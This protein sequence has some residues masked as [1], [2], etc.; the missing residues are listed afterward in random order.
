MMDERLFRIAPLIPP[1]CPL[2]IY[3]GGALIVNLMAELFAN[4]KTVL[5]PVMAAGCLT[6]APIGSPQTAGDP[7]LGTVWDLK[8]LYADAAA[9]E[10]DRASVERSLPDLAHLQ[11]SLGKDAASLQAGL[12]RISRT[13]QRLTRLEEYARLKADEDTSIAENQARWQSFTSLQAKFEEAIAFL[14]PE[15]LAMGRE[16]I[17]SFEREDPKLEC[18]RRELELILRRAPHTLSPE[19]ESLVA[20]TGDMRAGPSAIHDLLTYSDIPWPSIEVQGKPTRVDMEG[21]KRL[22]ENPDRD[23]RRKAFGAFT[24]TWSAYEQTLGG[25][26]SSYLA[27]SAFEARVRHYPGSLELLV[28]DDA[29]PAEAFQ[30]LVAETDK[31]IPILERY[32][33]LRKQALD[34]DDLRLYDLAVPLAN[35]ERSYRLDQA[36]DLILKALAPLGDDYVRQ[37]AAGFQGHAMHAIVAPHKP[38]GAYSFGDVHGVLP[39][40]L[41]S[42]SGNFDSVS[43]VAHE[44]GHSMHSQLANNA[45]PP[46]TS[47]YSFFIGDTPSF[48][49]E[50]LLSDYM[51][52]HAGNR[53]EKIVALSHAID[54]LRIYYFGT[55]LNVQF[56]MAAHEAADR[57]QPL[58]GE[59]FGQ[60]YCALLKHFNP[61]VT[62]GTADCALWAN[63][64]VVY[65]DFYMYKYMTA[66]SAAAYFV[67]GLEKDDANVRRCYFELLKAG[68]SDDPYALLKRAGF[69]AKSGEAYRPVVRRLD[70]LLTE[71]EATVADSGLRTKPE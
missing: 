40:V 29:M 54:L 1:D 18:H 43:A 71:L 16:R 53:Q 13:R 7:A 70:R 51:I 22:L 56:E 24:G 20:A 46:E 28:A 44:W 32:F 60:M 31:A 4:W 42:F 19:A 33:K 14:N 15:I 6:L 48:T 61:G 27:G 68:G 47:D 26:L 23:V 50:L 64:R 58:T 21:Y 55:L 36:E 37:L 41:V 52:A 35:D 17:K 10:R 59:R 63:A 67:E 11:G 5:L 9:W 45:Q 3:W 8:P 12:D 30:T 2:A 66:T 69:D 62:I 65:Y 39:F 49:N 25:V 38:A 57:G 34:V